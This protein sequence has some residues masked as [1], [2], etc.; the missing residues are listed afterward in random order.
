MRRDSSFA[1]LSLTAGVILASLTS[2]ATDADPA[3]SVAQAPA[4]AFP[5]GRGAA[6]PWIEH[7]A[8]D[9]PTNGTVLGPSRIKWDANHIEAEAIGRKA[10]R[11]SATGQYVAFHTTAAANSIVV[12]YSIPD[13]PG[14][15]GIDRT[16]GLYV[17]G[18]RVK[19]LQ[20]TSR[21]AWSYKGGLIGDPIVDIPAEQPHTFFDEIHTLLD[22]IPV[23]AEVKLQRDAQDTA[24]FY[25]ID[26]VDFEQVAPALTMPAGFRS[27]TEF[28]V[29]PNDGIDHATEIQNALRATTKLWF[30]PGEYIA[31]TLSNGNV[32]LDNP[33]A[34]VRGAGMW[35]TTLRGA[36]TMF[37]CIGAS[38]KCVYGDLAIFGES[39]ARA[40]ETQ[41]PQK[42]FA[43]PLGNGS[44]LENLWIEH[45]VAAIWVGND[46]PYQDAPTQFLTIRNSRIRNTYADGIN[47]DNG[48]S[49][50][51]VEN[52]H[53]R[54]TG[55][56]AAVVWS[57]Q[58]TRWVR[59]MTYRF[60]DG[61]IPANAKGAPDQGVGHGNTFRHLTVQMPWRANCFAAYG[62][63]D[64]V[65]EDNICE[66]VLTYPGILIDNEFSSYPFGSGLTT[67]RRISLA[68]AGGQ[69][70]L[71]ST[72]NPWKHG[73][74]K[75]Y[76]RE[77]NVNDILVENVDIIDPTYAG[78]EFRGFGA[79]YLPPGERVSPEYLAAADS[80]RYTNVTL[81][82]INITNAGTNGIEIVDNAGRGTVTF[83]GVSVA[84]SLGQPLV[85]GNA[86]GTFF[87]RINSNP[88][89]TPTGGGDPGNPG[90]NTNF[91]LN[92]PIA[93]SSHTQT[94]VASQAVDGNA[95][96]YWESA[97]NAFPQSVTVDLGAATSINKV[98]LKLPNP[99]WGTRT[100]TLS[101]LGSTDNNSFA[102]IVGATNVVFDPA[103]GN[104]A[105]LTFTATSQ[106]YVRIQITANTGWP[107]G[108]LSELEVYGP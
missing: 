71:E 63:Y 69:M 7:Q 37:F 87:N 90:G 24:A 88:G 54:N 13:A 101:I 40:E 42:A 65:F 38:T 33:G 28:G 100:Q 107:A 95:N 80:A 29:Q 93:E 25:V 89:W 82:N 103:N 76:M 84:G 91:A 43:G 32:G 41:G 74:L 96:T 56:D 86:P 75:L 14:G 4:S 51:L 21:Y 9:N 53:F 59:E 35:Y 19:T 27:I 62:G 39:K 22:P 105:T 46:P 12:R 18:A 55:D 102:T 34:E 61:Y 15:G 64:N 2:C 45:K 3:V 17:N 1:V 104:I 73:A 36:K 70:F 99:N 72:G 49:N 26:L 98:V 108:Q 83:D 5:A 106:R 50:S 57:I 52:V 10:V 8:E 44:L 48:T 77:G 6:V 11:L 58:W 92:R 85:Q 60:G 20:L 31:Q 97:N 67:F 94:Y 66:D 16:L 81:R 78:I 79:A 68:R 23:G 30:P 47:L